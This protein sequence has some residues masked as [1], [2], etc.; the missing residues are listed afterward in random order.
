[1]LFMLPPAASAGAASRRP[2][3][4]RSCGPARCRSDRRAHRRRSADRRGAAPGSSAASAVYWASVYGV[5]SPRADAD[6]TLQRVRPRHCRG[7]G[8]RRVR[9]RA[10]TARVRRR[11]GSECADTRSA[12]MSRKYGG[13]GRQHVREQRIDPRPAELARRQRDA[14]N[15]DQLDRHRLRARIVIRR[16]GQRRAAAHQ[17]SAPMRRLSAVMPLATA[18]GSASSCPVPGSARQHRSEPG[19]FAAGEEGFATRS[20]AWR[21]PAFG[22]QHGACAGRPPRRYRSAPRQDQHLGNQRFQERVM[23]VQPR[24]SVSAPCASSGSTWQATAACARPDRCS[25]RARPDRPSL[26]VAR[27]AR[28]RRA[29]S[30]PAAPQTSRSPACRWSR[31]R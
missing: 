10:R 12:A 23:R 25:R 14:V 3:P 4:D 7:P 22:R 28:A 21:Q 6:R 18:A 15:D 1:M 31:A 17:P 29:R 5:V 16:E 24:I 20:R 11:A 27:S 26:A 9:R 2:A 30:A 13:I 8:A 19:R